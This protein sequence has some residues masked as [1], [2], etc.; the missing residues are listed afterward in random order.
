[1]HK[2]LLARR[3]AADPAGCEGSWD[4]ACMPQ[5]EMMPRICKVIVSRPAG[6][7]TGE[8]ASSLVH[9]FRPATRPPCEPPGSLRMGK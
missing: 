3:G 5:A 9:E 4:R 2:L 7:R 1:M 8:A 6:W